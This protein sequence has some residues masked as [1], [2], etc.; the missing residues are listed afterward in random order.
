MT[1]IFI[2]VPVE[3]LF[4]FILRVTNGLAA[5]LVV[6]YPNDDCFWFNALKA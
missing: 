4:N 1:V 3:R 5:L 2:S 6:L